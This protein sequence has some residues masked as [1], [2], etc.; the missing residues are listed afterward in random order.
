[1]GDPAPNDGEIP[2]VHA[3][4]LRAADAENHAPAIVAQPAMAV[5]AVSVANYQVPPPEKFSFKPEDWTRWIR[6]FERF[7]KAAGLDQKSGGNQVKTLVYSMGE[8]ADDIMV[9]FGL[10]ADDVKQYELVKNRFESHFIVKRNMIFERAKFNLRSQQEGESVETFITDLHCLAEHCEFGVLKDELFRDRIVV[11][12]KDKKLSEKLQL[13]SKLTLEKAV[14]QARQSETVKKQQD[15]LQGTQPGPPSANV[16]QI[17]KKRGK[18]G[19]GKDQKDKPPKSSKLAGKTP[20]TKCTICLGTAHSKQECP[21]RDSKCNKCFKKGHWAKACKSQL[22]RKVEEVYSC[23]E[24]EL[25]GE[26]LLGQLTEVDMVEGSSKESWK[27]EVKLN[28]HA[29]KFKVDTGA[30]VTV[31]PPNIYRSLVPK[32]SLSKCDKTL[33]CPCK[34]KL[35]CLGN[36]IGS[37]SAARAGSFPEQRLV[38]EPRNFRAKLCVDDKVVRELIYVV[39]DLE[40]PLLGRDAAEKLK[41]VNRVDTVSSDD[42]K[43]KMANKQPK[44]FTGLS[45]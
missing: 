13:D 36:F 3:A 42:Y 5:Q 37:I 26:F 9:S 32:P 23:P 17:L 22:K 43:T 34:H 41:L 7:R 28:G 29:V 20:E 44:L 38:I 16:D 21:A 12:L 1:M 14:T 15:I 31:I 35:C 24:V 8:A 39:K 10:T 19:K 30:D 27:C 40:R 6:R 11:G 25:E 45:Q 2:P 4:Q 18:G 33:M